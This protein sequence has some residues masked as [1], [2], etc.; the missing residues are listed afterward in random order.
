M[1]NPNTHASIFPERTNGGYGPVNASLLPDS[2]RPA[3][4]EVDAGL[5]AGVD[6]TPEKAGNAVLKVFGIRTDD[7]IF[8]I[9]TVETYPPVVPASI[10]TDQDPNPAR[11]F[12][13]PQ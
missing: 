10:L 6:T 12:I 9:A 7:T 3:F 1:K 11:G 8:P 2:S 13:Y 4:T 5:V